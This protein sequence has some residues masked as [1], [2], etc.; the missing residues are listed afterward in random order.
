M[1][2]TAE[3]GGV[4]LTPGEGEWLKCRSGVGVGT[5]AAVT[6]FARSLETEIH[7][8][9]KGQITLAYA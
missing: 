5:L 3:G 7:T 8:V 4:M 2:S 1:V 9:M 6:L